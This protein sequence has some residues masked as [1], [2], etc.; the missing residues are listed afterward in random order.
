MKHPRTLLAKMRRRCQNFSAR[1]AV[2]EACD[3]IASTFLI[4]VLTFTN[5]K[6]KNMFNVQL[7]LISH[8]HE[9]LAENIETEAYKQF[10]LI[11]LELG[12][13]KN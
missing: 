4:E 12:V 13:D 10:G 7:A 2:H 8:L 11:S 1:E 3:V 5:F 9:H 6:P